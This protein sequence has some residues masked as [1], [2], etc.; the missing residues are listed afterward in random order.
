MSLPRNENKMSHE[1][2]MRLIMRPF[3][4]VRVSTPRGNSQAPEWLK[5]REQHRQDREE[6]RYELEQ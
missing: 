3:P 4:V 2:R 6:V 5:R 1:D